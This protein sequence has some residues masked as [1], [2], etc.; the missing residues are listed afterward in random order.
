MSFNGF[1]ADREGRKDKGGGERS[2]IYICLYVYRYICMHVYIY[3][4]IW[5]W[6]HRGRYLAVEVLN[7]TVAGCQC[8]YGRHDSVAIQANTITLTVQVFPKMSSNRTVQKH[9]GVAIFPDKRRFATHLHTLLPTLGQ[10]SGS[11]RHKLLDSLSGRETRACPPSKTL[12]GRAPAAVAK[13]HERAVDLSLCHACH[14]EVARRHGRHARLNQVQ[15]RHQVPC[16]PRLPRKTTVD[17]KLCHPC[18]VKQRKVDV[19]KCHAC[20]AEV[21]RSHGRHARLNQAQ[22]RH[23]VP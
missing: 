8:N 13:T 4:Y 19:T 14:A 6:W 18:H 10:T 7:T 23:P 11:R 17:V 15:A 20:H 1:S 21:A 5:R 9:R 16:V 12:T 22:A 2:C 3:L